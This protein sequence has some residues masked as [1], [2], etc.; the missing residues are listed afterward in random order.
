VWVPGEDLVSGK[1]VLVPYEMVHAD[2]T[3]AG[4]PGAG[5]FPSSTNGLASGNTALEA[6]CHAICEVVE[7]DALSIWH[8][9]SARYQAGRRIDL[10]TVDDTAC[11]EMIDKFTIAGLECGLW[12]VTTDTGVATFL[13]LIR[14]NGP[15]AGH[16][17]LGSGTH[18][19]R[20]VACMRAL[21]E[22]AQTR[23]NYISGAREDLGAEE[24]DAAGMDEKAGAFDEMFAMGEGTFAFERAPNVVNETLQQDL[25]SL[26]ERLSDV[27]VSEVVSVDLSREDFGVPVTRVIIPGLEAPHDD[28]SYIAGPRA[29]A[30]AL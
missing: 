23:L 12:D 10:G 20:R 17:G 11:C 27:G 4:H 14:D 9:C 7:R 29:R 15:G 30:V 5:C 2:Y 24:Y 25:E 6:I 28:D 26:L 3:M 19:D 8:A 1:T 21:T 13:C 18:L 22:A 16:L